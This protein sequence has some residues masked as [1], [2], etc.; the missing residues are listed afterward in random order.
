MPPKKA[1][2]PK[3]QTTSVAQQR[4]AVALQQQKNAELKR[5]AEAKKNEEQRKLFQAEQKRKAEL[6]KQKEDNENKK[7]KQ[8]EDAQKKAAEQSQKQ[9]ESNH[10]QKAKASSAPKKVESSKE[11][12]ES[13]IGYRYSGES[14]G[15]NSFSKEEVSELATF[16]HDHYRAGRNKDAN[17]MAVDSL[18]CELKE[19]QIL[20][21]S[22]FVGE[23]FIK[24]KVF[25]EFF[26]TLEGR[27]ELHEA[28]DTLKLMGYKVA[29]DEDGNI[30]EYNNL[31]LGNN[32]LSKLDIEDILGVNLSRAEDIGDIIYS[33]EWLELNKMAYF[34][35]GEII[36][37]T[38]WEKIYAD[39]SNHGLYA[40]AENEF[41]QAKKEFEEFS[42]IETDFERNIQK[43]Q[44]WTNLSKATEKLELFSKIKSK[45]VE[46]FGEDILEEVTLDNLIDKGYAIVSNFLPEVEEKAEEPEKDEAKDS[47]E[48]KE[49]DSSAETIKDLPAINEEETIYVDETEE[50][51]VLVNHEETYRKDSVFEEPNILPL[52][53]KSLDIITTDK[54]SESAIPADETPET[55]IRSE[56][57]AEPIV[58]PEETDEEKQ[59]KKKAEE[60]KAAAEAEAKRLAEREDFELFLEFFSS[61][62]KMMFDPDNPFLVSKLSQYHLQEDFSY[63]DSNPEDITHNIEDTRALNRKDIELDLIYLG[64][65]RDKIYQFTNDWLMKIIALPNV[66]KILHLAKNIDLLSEERA[67]KSHLIDKK[68]LVDLAINIEPSFEKRVDICAEIFDQWIINNQD[69]LY[70]EIVMKYLTDNEINVA[71][72]FIENFKTKVMDHFKPLDQESVD[73]AVLF[74]QDFGQKMSDQKINDSNWKDKLMPVQLYMDRIEAPFEKILLTLGLPLINGQ[75]NCMTQVIKE[76][77]NAKNYDKIITLSKAYHHMSGRDERTK[78][79]PES[80]VN[81]YE[82]TKPEDFDK[83]FKDILEEKK[84][85]PGQLN[86]T[87]QQIIDKHLNKIKEEEDKILAKEKAEEEAILAEAARL[88]EEDKIK[89]A[90]SATSSELQA[91]TFTDSHD[92]TGKLSEDGVE[93]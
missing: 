77:Y 33:S 27:K 45:I 82:K 54:N 22:E 56:E 10:V 81:L 87:P 52:D 74:L 3:T 62:L 26:K 85:I 43:I 50:D 79:S 44:A 36:T 4:Q 86:P 66:W 1:P 51:A 7:L 88:A 39:E 60:E 90:E 32:A 84:F 80:L 68:I 92:V 76:C 91:E 65:E 6:K 53:G 29:L 58:A 83:I 18:I 20:V 30:H 23:H 14:M 67:S 55:I 64:P 93:V 57:T 15:E 19:L 61:E 71:S 9:I 47:S 75:S 42:E 25:I 17:H 40:A 38:D 5:Q 35:N 16:I 70:L 11:Y 78:I 69:N 8:A 28:K 46:D 41:N 63:T 13:Y 48:S 59:A 49:V 2:P 72:N 21:K 89:E 24:K 12:F 73:G 31:E 34:S 37:E